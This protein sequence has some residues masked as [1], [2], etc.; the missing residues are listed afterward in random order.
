MAK[1]KLKILQ[2]IVLVIMYSTKFQIQAIQT[3]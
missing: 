3:S 1:D 2:Q